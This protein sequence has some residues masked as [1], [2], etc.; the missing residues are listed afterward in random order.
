MR[1]V[2]FFVP[3]TPKEL[4]IFAQKHIDMTE[5]EK[6]VEDFKKM[7]IGILAESNNCM[8]SQKAFKEAK[9]VPEAVTAWM[10]YF[11]GVVDEVPRQVA[12]AFAKM[13]DVYKEDVNKAGVYFNEEPPEGITARV[14]IVGDCD[15]DLTI[16]ARHKVYVLGKAKV[17]LIEQAQATVN[18]PDAEIYAYDAARVTMRAGRAW[19]FDSSS[20]V[21]RGRV[22]AHNDCRIDISGGDV[23][24]LGHR[25]I[26]AYGDTIVKARSMQ[27][28][29]LHDRAR[30]EPMSTDN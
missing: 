26:S 7:C 25:V 20:F 28:V 10:H 23:F 9:S 14:V 22:Y 4:C 8:E 1:I 16:G 5:K 17:T 27:H 18:Y 29:Y 13:Y 3:L 21:G 11:A 15:K 24:S 2:R 6:Y 30:E 19:M 12:A